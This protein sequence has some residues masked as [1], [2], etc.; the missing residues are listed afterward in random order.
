MTKSLQ[1]SFAT[2]VVSAV[3]AWASAPVGPATIQGDVKD[4]F[5]GP[6][7]RRFSGRLIF[8]LK[9]FNFM[10]CARARWKYNSRNVRTIPHARAHARWGSGA[11]KPIDAMVALSASKVVVLVR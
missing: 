5:F 8:F 7:R 10:M 6:S 4:S 2:L 11:P 1:I 3:A 9:F